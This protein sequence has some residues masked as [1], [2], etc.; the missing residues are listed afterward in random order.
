MELSPDGNYELC[1]MNYALK[2]QLCNFQI[3]NTLNAL[4]ISG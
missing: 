2:K 1:I 3:K 4:K